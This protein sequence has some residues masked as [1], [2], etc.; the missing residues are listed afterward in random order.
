MLTLTGAASVASYQAALELVT[1]SS[2][3]ANPALGP[4]SDPSDG[5]PDLL[6][7]ISFSAS[8]GSQ[9]SSVLAAY[10]SVSAGSGAAVAQAVSAV[11]VSLPTSDPVQTAAALT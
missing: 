10:V 8:D 5:G 9:A 11:S 7:T 1:F 2:A 6:R 3:A 4:A